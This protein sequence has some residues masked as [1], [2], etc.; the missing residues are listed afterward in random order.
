MRNK[1]A[2]KIM[3]IQILISVILSFVVVPGNATAKEPNST[4]SETN[5]AT[6]SENVEA[7]GIDEN[8]FTWETVDGE[9]YTITGY[10][11]SDTNITIPS[12]I[13]GHVVTKIGDNAFKDK[14]LTSV[15]IP[16]TVTSIGNFAFYYNTS[17]LSVTIPNSVT[18][19]GDSAFAYCI[20]LESIILPIN[21]EKIGNSTFQDCKALKAITIPNSVKSIGHYA[22][23]E[24]YSLISITIPDSVT[25]IGEAAFKDCKNL[26]SVYMSDSVTSVGDYLFYNCQKLEDVR[27]SNNLTDTGDFMFYNCFSLEGVTLPSNLKVIGNSAFENCTSLKTIIIPNGVTKIGYRAFIMCKLLENII[28]PNT[29]EI[30]D[31]NAFAHCYGFTNIVIPNSVKSIGDYAF[32]YNTN[33]TEIT[34]PKSVTEIGFLTFGST[35]QSFKIKGD[36]GSYAQNYAGSNS[37]LFEELPKTKYTVS[38]NS[39]GGSVIGNVQIDSGNLISVPINPIKTGYTFGGWYKEETYSTKWNFTTDKVTKNLTLFAKWKKNPTIPQNLK[40]SATYN[41][42]SASWNAVT[43]VSGYEVWRS[44]GSTGN[45]SLVS[46]TSDTS[47]KNTTLGTGSTYTYKVRAYSMD[48]TVKAYSDFTPIVSAKTVLSVP[49]GVKS[50]STEY[51]SITTSWSAIAGASG[52][53]VWRSTSS[54]GTYSLIKTT[55]SSNFKN[56]SLVT[57]KTYYFKVRAYIVVGN[58]KVYSSFS[59]ITN[60]KPTLGVPINFKAIRTS[61]TSIK[62]SWDAVAGAS[63]YEVYTSSYSGGPYRLVKTATSLNFTNFGLLKGKTY[64]YK[65]RAY[66]MIGTTKIYSNFSVVMKAT[67]Y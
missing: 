53:E 38:F 49:T 12:S 45:Y 43:G 26:K 56:T 59:P 62:T 29:V 50:I 39:V 7:T 21:L 17:L 33:L 32:Y 19:I 64:Y 57:G 51:N 66:K 37:V 31:F 67:T 65:V 13:D 42:I 47:F 41:S 48:G 20:S 16:N 63:G 18:S 22:F 55:T 2:K 5:I 30:I 60:S 1:V 11:G 44:T 24:C 14:A 40:L 25:Y 15:I 61:K 8:G 23:F 4:V 58:V 28:I 35:N 10:S 54:T 27:L 9:F 34:I 52:Y 6:N 46:T 36:G 3:T